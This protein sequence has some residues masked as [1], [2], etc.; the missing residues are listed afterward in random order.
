MQSAAVSTLISRGLKVTGP[1]R[2][3]LQILSDANPHHLSADEV[4][5]RLAQT[6][7]RISLGTVYRVLSQFQSAG[8]VRRVYFAGSAAMFELSR[9][10]DHDHIV[11]TDCGAIE[12][13]F[14]A[15]SEA[16]RR[17]VAARFGTRLSKH[18]LVIHAR[19]QKLDCPNRL[20]TKRLLHE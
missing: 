14:D 4:Y 17:E 13:F 10:N 2:K 3:V 9:G 7:E 8:M 12:E 16:R 19:C 15:V 6:N 20:Q 11:C 5:K 1:R 18:S